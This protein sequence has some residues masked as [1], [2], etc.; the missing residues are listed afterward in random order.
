MPNS[1][2]CDSRGT[3]T[4]IKNNVL[5]RELIWGAVFLALTFGMIILWQWFQAVA[6]R[7]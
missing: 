7:F 1:T 6:F 3:A 5:R 2:S 4:P